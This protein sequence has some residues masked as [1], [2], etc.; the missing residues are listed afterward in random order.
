[1]RRGLLPV[2]VAVALVVVA[3]GVS[4]TAVMAQTAPTIF[5]VS[6]SSNGGNADGAS[7]RASPSSDGRFIAF[8]SDATNLVPGDFNGVRDVFVRDVRSG[9]TELVSVSSTG[10]QG[11]QPSGDPSI[12][13]DGRF[14]AFE[15]DSPNLV[16]GDTN[17]DSD[18]F[19]HDRL[20]QTTIRASVTASGDQPNTTSNNPALS[21]TGRFVAF[22][23]FAVNMTPENANGL[24]QVYTRDLIAGITDR[25][26]ENNAGE[27][28]EEAAEEA[29]ISADGR[30]VAF[31]SPAGNLS[32][33]DPNG[34]FDVFLRDRQAGTTTRVSDNGGSLETDL[35][36]GSPSLTPDGR[37]IA[38]HALSP[39]LR[40]DR[41]GFIDV[42]LKNLQTGKITL[43]SVAGARMQ[44]N[45][46]S[47]VPSVSDDGRFVAFESVASN[48]VP[49]DT[50]GIPDIFLRDVQAKTTRRMNVSSSGEQANDFS[51]DRSLAVSGDGR[52]VVFTSPATNLVVDDTNLVA[53]IFATPS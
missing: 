9:A 27:P 5:R 17:N 3:L 51:F 48:L 14:V 29:S 45:H 43:V 46:Q 44:G 38:F 41:N 23:S 2:G 53:D 50:N 10:E 52:S 21:A 26:S 34:N 30:L 35:G 31:S 12:S 49:N 1:M 40:T 25:V 32:P 13:A 16:S 33:G 8:E 19:V 47:V 7:D 36:A 11:S 4:A 6:V 15:S 24:Q 39:M 20:A 22:T 28:G 18:V 37:F 42:Y